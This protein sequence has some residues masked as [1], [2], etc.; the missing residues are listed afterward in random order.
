MSYIATFVAPLAF[1]R[2]SVLLLPFTLLDDAG[3]AG[4]SDETVVQT[5]KMASIC[6]SHILANLSVSSADNVIA[7]TGQPPDC[8][9][10]CIRTIISKTSTRSN[11]PSY[12][13]AR[14]LV[15]SVRI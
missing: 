1:R 7:S 2:L 15:I 6:L 14:S 5:N 9:R 11:P 4:G 12:K 8:G 10:P 13:W 3:W